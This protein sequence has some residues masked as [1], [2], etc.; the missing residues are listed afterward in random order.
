[1]C[2]GR[3]GATL[4]MCIQSERSAVFSAVRTD[5][6]K[7]AYFP[8]AHLSAV[9]CPFPSSLFDFIIHHTPSPFL[10]IKHA[11]LPLLRGT[12]MLTTVT[13]EEKA[14]ELN[15]PASSCLSSNFECMQEG[16]TCKRSGG[17]KGSEKGEEGSRP[18]KIQCANPP[19]Q[20]G[21][22]A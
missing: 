10:F 14:S 8:L 1:M 17:K 2:E 18:S 4:P 22:D 16:D 19:S 6:R 21:V 7:T 12:A 13:L 3:G 5:H 20:H 9:S 11:V 15:I